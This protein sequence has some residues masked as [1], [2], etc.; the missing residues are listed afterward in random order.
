VTRIHG[1]QCEQFETASA[2]G[3]APGGGDDLTWICINGMRD[4]GQI[5]RIEDL[6]GLHHLTS[7]DILNTDHITKL[8]VLENYTF[9]V[10]KSTTRPAGGDPQSRQL[11][12]VAGRNF[13]VSFLEGDE[14]L[15]LP[16]RARIKLEHA[17]F[18]KMGPG[19]LAYCLMDMAVDRYFEVLEFIDDE[20]YHLEEETT[21]F[22]TNENLS[23]IQVLRR[24]V[25]MVRRAAWPLREVINNLHRRENFIRGEHTDIYFNDIY[26]HVVQVVDTTET[27]RE[28]LSNIFDI[29]LTSS[30]NRINEVVKVLTIITTVVMPMTVVT[31]L[32]GMNFKHMPELSWIYG[33]PMSIG[34][35]LLIG[36][37]ML[38][39][40]KKRD[41]L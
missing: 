29:Y 9:I 24:K 8:D 36:L 30:G 17:A 1:D 25:I 18:L 19:Y 20:I 39:F 31:G 5:A 26:D 22:S 21:T 28:V 38:W 40:F 10:M 23:R 7:E 32:Y 14:D 15:F 13:L 27:F 35:M 2:D 34:I 11:S 16:L 41:W 6:Y 33:Y 37:G 12:F 4:N 3:C